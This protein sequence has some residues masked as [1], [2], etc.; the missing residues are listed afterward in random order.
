LEW[1]YID[2]L[3]VREMADRL[4]RTEKAVESVLFRARAAFR[5]LFE[6]IAPADNT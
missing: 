6:R 1:K 3:S 4:G 2:G 5:T